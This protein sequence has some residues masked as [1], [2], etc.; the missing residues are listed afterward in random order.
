MICI[1]WLKSVHYIYDIEQM[2]KES[3]KYEHYTFV[4]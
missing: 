1:T 2:V 3:R 4:L